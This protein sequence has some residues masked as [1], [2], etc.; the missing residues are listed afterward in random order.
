M[1]KLEPYIRYWWEFKMVQLLQ[2]GLEVPQ[3]VEDKI[4]IYPAIPLLD[5]QL[6]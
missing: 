1:E 4:T 6:K 3:K 5:I 2:K